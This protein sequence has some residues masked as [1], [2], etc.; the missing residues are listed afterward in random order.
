MLGADDLWDR[1][2]TMPQMDSH[3][4]PR[5]NIISSDTGY[6]IEVA[7]PGWSREDLTVELEKSVLVV[8]G[9]MQ[10]D[11]LEEKENYIHKGLSTKNFRRTFSIGE[12]LVLDQAYLDSGMLNIE[13]SKYIPEA[14]LPKLIEIL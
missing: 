11:C 9:E 12:N 7:V 1:V 8:I 13:F 3:S 6:R 2:F 4:H 5:Y 14:E 10:Q